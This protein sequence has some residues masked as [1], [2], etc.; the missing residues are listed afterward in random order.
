MQTPHV[1]LGSWVHTEWVGNALWHTSSL[2]NSGTC[3]SHSFSPTPLPHLASL[4]PN[5]LLFFIQTSL[6]SLLVLFCVTG[7]D[8]II[9]FSY[10]GVVS[11]CGWRGALCVWW[12]SG[13]TR[14]Y[15]SGQARLEAGIGSLLLS[16]GVS[17]IE[18][19]RPGCFTYCNAIMPIS[20]HD[21]LCDGSIYVT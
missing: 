21:L 13:C 8:K 14:V 5:L 12:G 10:N 20:D 17:G 16:W 15:C 6:E 7:Q 1:A 18:L 11:V 4:C 2:Q 9:T 3:W 19:K